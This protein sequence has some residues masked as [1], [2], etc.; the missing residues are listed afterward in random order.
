MR[1]FIMS[2]LAAATLASPVLADPPGWAGNPHERR[3][4]RGDRDDWRG[5][6]R[7]EWH[8]RRDWRDGRWDHRDWRY[9]QG[10]WRG[11]AYYHPPGYSYRAWR[12]GAVLPPAYWGDRYWIAE[13]AYYRLPPPR[14]GTRWVRVGPDALLIRLGDGFIVQVVRGLYW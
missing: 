6:E 2:V 9:E 5:G 1:T 10:R 13:P 14:Y 4:W 8:G 11:P 12:A 7:R 3:E